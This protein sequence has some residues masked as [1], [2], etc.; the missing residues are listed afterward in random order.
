MVSRDPTHSIDSTMSIQETQQ[1]IQGSKLE[2]IHDGPILNWYSTPIP[3]LEIKSE[4][5]SEIKL[6]IKLKI[7]SELTGYYYIVSDGI[8]FTGLSDI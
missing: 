2:I 3:K 7:K 1:D 4:I 8:V 5:K 6:K